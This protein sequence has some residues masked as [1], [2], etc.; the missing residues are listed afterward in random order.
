[1]AANG[2]IRI[3][4]VSPEE[5]AE[6]SHGSQFEVDVLGHGWKF[7][8]PPGYA[9]W[10][11]AVM[12]VLSRQLPGYDPSAPSGGLTEELFEGVRI[13]LPK[14]HR[15]FLRLYLSIASRLDYYHG[16]DA[17][18]C[19]GGV[20]VTL[21]VTTNPLKDK[22]A[23]LLI[24]PDDLTVDSAG[25]VKGFTKAL[26]KKIRTLLLEKYREYQYT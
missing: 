12:E 8:E 16:V 7:T 11:E 3:K 26:L 10:S 20:Y 6:L 13:Y 25:K 19:L 17:F 22:K 4:T 23:D 21:D 1:M 9:P 2:G 14:R 18:F 24:T 15:R 5:F